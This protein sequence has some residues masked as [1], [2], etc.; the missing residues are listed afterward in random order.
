MEE[1]GHHFSQEQMTKLRSHIPLEIP[2]Q[3]DL[4]IESGIFMI[5]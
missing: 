5:N 1:D 2:Y 4:L 3:L